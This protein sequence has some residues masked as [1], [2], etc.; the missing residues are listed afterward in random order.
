MIKV[1]TSDQINPSTGWPIDDTEAAQLH[2]FNV[3]EGGV[4]LNYMF[5]LS[6]VPE[7]GVSIR[8]TAEILSEEPPWDLTETAIM[9]D[10]GYYDLMPG[11]WVSNV[12]FT[13]PIADG[14][15]GER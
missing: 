10:S 15:T 8:I 6:I 5:P 3:M 2:E 4:T 14:D 7:D 1:W 13:I 9:P 12:D 11:D